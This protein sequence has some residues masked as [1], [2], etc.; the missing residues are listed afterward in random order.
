[1][2]QPSHPGGKSA[3]ASGTRQYHEG[4]SPGCRHRGLL[5]L[6]RVSLKGSKLS[7]AATV[8]CNRRQTTSLTLSALPPHV[9]SRRWFFCFFLR[10]HLN[11]GYETGAPC[12]LA[13]SRLGRGH[14]LAPGHHLHA[15]QGAE[16]G[17]QAGNS[18]LWSGAYLLPSSR[19][20]DFKVFFLLFFL[21]QNTLSP[22]T[23]PENFHQPG[24][25]I[26]FYSCGPVGRGRLVVRLV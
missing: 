2:A 6:G 20:D 22:P 8:G 18:A 25:L 16:V 21:N 17:L 1:M 23:P 10:L 5:C 12:V 19:L 9:L 15:R 24:Q 4:D 11:T 26:S 3:R 13:G 14:R 7:R